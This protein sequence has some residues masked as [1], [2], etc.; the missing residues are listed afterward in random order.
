MGEARRR[1]KFNAGAPLR[2]YAFHVVPMNV[3]PEY[4]MRLALQAEG[5]DVM[6][7]RIVIG[8]ERAV[9][10]LRAPFSPP[11]FCGCCNALVAKT[12]LPPAFILG[13]EHRGPGLKWFPVCAEC[14]AP[15]FDPR[16]IIAR[17]REQFEAEF[18]GVREV[19]PPDDETS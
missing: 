12:D 11:A 5:G 17:F 16:K 10:T 18:P 15:P 6:A 19:A 1:Q 3:P 4:F 13:F 8:L 7:Q 14:C 9:T 2:P